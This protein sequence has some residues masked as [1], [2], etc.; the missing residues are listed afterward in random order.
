[1][2]EA[3]E[4]LSWGSD[5]NAGDDLSHATTKILGDH[6]QVGQEPASVSECD[7]N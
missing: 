4:E 2:I 1:M 3:C 7:D 6:L 5:A